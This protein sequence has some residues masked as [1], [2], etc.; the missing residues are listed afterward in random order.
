MT[1]DMLQIFKSGV[2]MVSKRKKGKEILV[3]SGDGEVWTGNRL[4]SGPLWKM[5]EN[6][7]FRAFFVLGMV[8]WRCFDGYV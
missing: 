2:K 3:N 5:L 8:L 4:P 6:T 1:M 7:G